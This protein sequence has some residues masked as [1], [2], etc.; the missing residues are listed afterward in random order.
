[1]S[2]HERQS[3]HAG[4]I[5]ASE[6]DS[7]ARFRPWTALNPIC[8]ALWQLA[9]LTSGT[10]AG[11]VSASTTSF[12]ANARQAHLRSPCDGGCR[13]GRE[14]HLDPA[15]SRKE[16]VGSSMADMHVPAVAVIAHALQHFAFPAMSRTRTHVASSLDLQVYVRV[17]VFYLKGGGRFRYGTP[18][19]RQNA[20][21]CCH[22]GNRYY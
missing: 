7:K 4:K 13:R 19:V 16:S 6:I 15:N 17:F 12:L 18:M 22:D 9:D 10:T 5:R 14:S 2:A 1:M 20:L 11:P 8:K 21:C 3:P